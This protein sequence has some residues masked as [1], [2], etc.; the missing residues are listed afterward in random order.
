MATGREGMGLGSG[1]LRCIFTTAGRTDWG[2][3]GGGG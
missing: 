2:G 3:G 1:V